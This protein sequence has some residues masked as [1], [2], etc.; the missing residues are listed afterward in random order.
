MIVP[1]SP[2]ASSP[3]PRGP[4]EFSPTGGN[5][6]KAALTDGDIWPSCQQ[7]SS[8]RASG[9]SGAAS[10]A[11]L[12]A[13]AAAPSA[14]APIWGMAAACPAARA[15]AAAARD[16]TSRAAPPAMNRRR[17]PSATPSSQRAKARVRAIAARGRLSCGASASNSSSTRSAQSAAH[18]A[19]IRRS[20]SLSACGE[21]ILRSFHAFTVAPSMPRIVGLTAGRRGC[22]SRDESGRPP[23][24]AGR[25]VT[26]AV[27]SAGAGKASVARCASLGPRD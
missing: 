6:R 4:A 19:T 24:A 23:N 7:I 25:L 17:I 13:Y 10:P 1:R 2:D 16:F 18:A 22:A 11:A 20:P 8:L 21:V 5:C 14:C 15:A 9:R 3:R 12:A 26:A 27:G